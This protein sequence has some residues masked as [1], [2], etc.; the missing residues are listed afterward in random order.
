MQ[1]P[2]ESALE[3]LDALSEAT[4]DWH[5][6]ETGRRTAIRDIL[7][8]RAGLYLSP[9]TVSGTEYKTGGTQVPVIIMPAVIRECKDEQGSALYEAIGYYVQFLVP[10][11]SHR[12]T[13]LGTD[14]GFYGCLWTGKELFVEPLTPL[15][16]LTTSWLEETDRKVIASSLDAFLEVT[17]KLRDHY[18]ELKQ[19]TI[20]RGRCFPYQTGYK[21]E[22]DEEINFEYDS[23]IPETLIFF[24][25]TNEDPRQHLC[26]KFTRRYSESAHQIL[27]DLGL[28]PRLRAVMGLPGGWLMVVMDRSNYTLLSEINLSLSPQ[29]QL[30]VKSRVLYAVETLHKHNLVHGDIREGTVI[31]PELEIGTISSRRC[32]SRSVT[33]DASPAWA[34]IRLDSQE[35][36]ADAITE[37]P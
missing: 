6:D 37:T 11:L 22:M 29:A 32:K 19:T 30:V 3:L 31:R 28:A 35:A 25:R 34:L 7:N 16:H 12:G 23:K 36:G 13:R 26:V 1:P 14:M 9:E 4:C 33:S 5:R 27:A 2:S 21:S 10:Q 8:H 15:Y 18:S 17:K 20:L 24:A